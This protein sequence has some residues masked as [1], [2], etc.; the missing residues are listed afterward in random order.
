[1]K[2][3]LNSRRTGIGRGGGGKGKKNRHGWRTLEKQKYKE[4]EKKEQ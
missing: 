2:E 1:M 4:T 3:R